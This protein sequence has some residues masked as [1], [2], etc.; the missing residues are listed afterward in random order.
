MSRADR[1]TSNILSSGKVIGPDG[2]TN[3]FSKVFNQTLLEAH[4][5][6]I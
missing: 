4:D 6:H 2:F 3:D 1:N 5:W